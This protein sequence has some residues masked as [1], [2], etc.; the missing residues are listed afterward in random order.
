MTATWQNIKCSAGRSFENN[1]LFLQSA[2]DVK[3]H[4]VYTCLICFRYQGVVYKIVVG[5]MSAN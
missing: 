1:L 5:E 2:D 3:G 4:V